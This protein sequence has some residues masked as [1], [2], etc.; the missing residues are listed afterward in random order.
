MKLLDVVFLI[1]VFWLFSCNTNSE[2]TPEI[3]YLGGDLSYVNEMLDCGAVYRSE[4]Q[5]L[6]PYKI[7]GLKGA[8]ISRLRLWHSPEWTDYSDYK[9]VELAIQR[10]KDSGME[11]LLDFHY[12]DTWA[13]PQHQVIPKAW[14]EVTDLQILMDSLYQYTYQTLARLHAKGLAPELVQVGNEVNIEIMQDS[15]NMIVDTID[16]NRNLSLINAGLKAVQDFSKANALEI[17]TM[18]HIA[19]P[20]NALWWFGEAQKNG[21]SDFDWIGL[22][23]YPK[24]SVYGLDSLSIAIDSLINTYQKDL[25]IVETAYPYTLE[26]FDPGNNI[27]GAEALIAG[28]EASPD[29]QYNFMN[30]LI[31]ITRKSGGRG[32]IYWEPAW[33]STEC[34][35]P[36]NQGSNWENATFFDAGNGNEAMKVFET[37]R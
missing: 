10:S 16:W 13:D 7:F 14:Q 12:S 24:W 33:V 27:L 17:E 18:I 20:E 22:S 25:M 9:D 32:V 21:L 23:Y 31:E 34:S 30:K 36:W 37:F 35:T 6:D 28:Y 19:Q 1:A 11:V 5:P 29:G 26:N 4:G 15:A 3:F 2:R 8:N